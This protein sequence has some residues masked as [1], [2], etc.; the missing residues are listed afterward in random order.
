MNHRNGLLAAIGVFFFL[1]FL[2]PM[3]TPGAATLVAAIT[4]PF[5]HLGIFV[6]EMGHGLFTLLSGGRF[7]WFQMEL[8]QGGIAVTSGG[9]RVFTLL[10]GLLGPTIFGVAL[11][12]VSTRAKNVRGALWV[13]VAFF[14][15]GLYYMIKPLFLSE[16]RYGLLDQWQPMMLVSMVVPG[17][18]AILSYKL[19]SFSD[20]IQRLYLQIL[21]ILMCYSG[22]SDTHYIF[23]YEP[24]GNGMYSDARMVAA[25]FWPDA[26]SVPYPLFLIVATA[27]TVLNFGLMAWGVWRAV[28]GPGRAKEVGTQPAT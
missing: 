23:R 26:A 28:S 25:L 1:W 18:A 19:M 12:L 8:M 3:V 5:R 6:H 4:L 11:L 15:I 24:L 20:K 9:W 13:L 10:G 2:V 16:A 27:I 14:I 22:Y 21:G 17:G 7:H